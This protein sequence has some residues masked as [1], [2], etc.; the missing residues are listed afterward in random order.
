M[1]FTKMHGIGNDFIMINCFKEKMP[2]DLN[3]TARDLCDRH[4]GIGADGMIC[5]LPSKK[6]DL[7]MVLINSDGCEGEMCGNGI[8]CLAKF[9]FDEGVIEQENITVETSAGIMK[10]RLISENGEII[11]VTVDIGEPSFRRQ[12]IPMTGPA[13]RVINEPL[14]VLDQTFAITAM[15]LGVPH[16]VIFVEDVDKVDLFKY[17]PALEIHPKF[18]KKTNVN[19]VQVINRSELKYR[20]WERAA[21]FTLACGTG[22]CAALVAAVL[23]DKTGRKAKIYLPGGTLEDEWAEDNHVYMTGPAQTV[24]AGE[25][26]ANPT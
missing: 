7:R 21:G 15:L 17:G 3:K 24:F 16:T 26:E 19:F 25:I 9:A 11:K 8:R 12:D 5:M 1:M 14:E 23:N 20:V 2:R 22:S 4:F 10:P 18:P 13:G 6:A